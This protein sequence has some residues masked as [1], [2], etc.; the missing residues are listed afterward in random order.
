MNFPARRLRFAGE[1]AYRELG[2]P[3]VKNAG[4]AVLIVR[5][6]PRAML[7][8]CPD[9]CGETLVVN[10]DSRAGKAWRLDMRGEGPT[11]YPSVWRDGGCESHFI[12]WRGSILWCGRYLSGN[13][14]P[15]RSE[16]LEEKVLDALDARTPRSVEELATLLDENIWDVDRAVTSLVQEG[17]AILRKTSLDRLFLLDR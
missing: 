4:D 8:A 9:G 14:E 12:V 1:V 11:L 7:L 15:D 17:E 3:M 13:E 5:G 2:E 6:R 10:L 16:G